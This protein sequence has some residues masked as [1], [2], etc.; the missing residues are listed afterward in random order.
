MSVN[1]NKLEI[2]KTQIWSMFEILRNENISTEDYYIVLLLLSAHKEGLIKSD[3]IH[4]HRNQIET[5]LVCL[6]NTERLFND[7]FRKV[8]SIFEPIIQQLSNEGIRNLI[9]ILYELDQKVLSENFSDVFDSVLFKL[10]QSVGRF[11]SQTVQPVEITRLMIALAQPNKKARI[12]NPF[13]GHASFGIHL[14]D[15]NYYF[16]QELNTKTWAIAVLRLM[17]HNKLDL[18]KFNCED[19]IKEWPD[20][21]EKFDLIISNPPI[22]MKISSHFGET[23]KSFKSVDRFTLEKGFNSL[24]KEGKMVLILPTGVLSGIGSGLRQFSEFL[25][26]NDLIETVISLPGGLFYNTGLALSILV[27][28]K[29]K[30]MPGKVFMVD[31][32][33]FVEVGNKREKMLNDI[34]LIDLLNGKLQDVDSMRIVDNESLKENEGRLSVPLYLQKQISGVKLGDI[35]MSLK[36]EKTSISEELKLV[37]ISNLKDDPFDCHLDLSVLKV[38]EANG[39]GFYRISESCLLLSSRTMSLKPTLFEYIG[40]PIYINHEVLAFSI[41]ETKVNKAYLINELHAE[42]VKEQLNAFRM[43]AVIP[44]IRIKDLF[45]VIIKL[46]SLD[47]QR[48]KVEGI[49]ELSEKIRRL[50]LEKYALA[51]GQNLK[52][53]ENFSTIKHALGKP[54]LN[55]GSSLRNIEK[56]LSK[57]SSNWEQLKLNE[58]FDITIKDSF[59]SVYNNLELIHAV[60]KKNESSF[61]VSNYTLSEIDFLKFI[62][63]YVKHVKSAAKNNISV[64][65][66][67]H[68]DI[69]KLLNNKISIQ[70]NT[71]LLEIAFN[72]IVE[73]AYMHAFTDISKKYKLAFS[74]SLYEKSHTEE[75]LGSDNF[76]KI[77]VANNGSSFPENFSLEKFIRKNSFAGETGN[78]GLGGYDLNEIIKYHNNGESTLEL[79]TNDLLTGYSTIYSFL[80]P[81]IK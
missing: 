16:G 64:I 74:I 71:E 63:D 72:T 70:S 54:L 69:E 46:P 78:T 33:K 67:V 68:S 51:Q 44:Y 34:A 11:S 62:N 57:V 22:G 81:I 32:K 41:I 1:M 48:A 5:L 66:D 8:V 43:G 9:S 21:S 10:S 6:K 58:R 20:S 31:A 36:G 53:Y 12:F 77:D 55:I 52:L 40:E 3:S 38:N 76:I 4:T 19:S 45:E 65:F 14:E 59:D 35:L 30:K 7:D 80:L 42:Y 49:I 39:T 61:D 50:Q 2:L 56:A 79:T 37:R 73:N 47:E 25:V 28:N 18:V 13:A 60:L 27:I 26:E 17:A 15:G 75:D 24:D 23:A 29:R